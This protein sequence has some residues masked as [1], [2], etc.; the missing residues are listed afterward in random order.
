LKSQNPQY[1]IYIL[2]SQWLGEAVTGDFLLELTD[3]IN[4]PAMQAGDIYESVS[5]CVE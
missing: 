1:D 5:F 4:D 3:V 2:D